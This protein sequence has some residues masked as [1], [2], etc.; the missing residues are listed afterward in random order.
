M[1]KY[2]EKPLPPLNLSQIG[3]I[4]PRRIRMLDKIINCPL[5]TWVKYIAK[6]ALLK[7]RIRVNAAAL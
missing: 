4:C 1:P 7:S 2:D 3:N 5:I 6:Q